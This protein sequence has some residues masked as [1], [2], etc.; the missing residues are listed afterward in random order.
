MVESAPS[1]TPAVEFGD[2]NRRGSTIII[3]HG[4]TRCNTKKH[5][6]VKI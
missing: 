3:Y 5:G 6:G 4:L 2:G 1:N